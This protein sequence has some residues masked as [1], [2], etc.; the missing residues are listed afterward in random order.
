MNPFAPA[1][2]EP[3]IGYPRSLLA[4]F[5]PLPRE[6]AYWNIFGIKCGQL[7][8]KRSIG[9]PYIYPLPGKPIEPPPEVAR[10]FVRDM[11]TFFAVGGTGV[12]ADEIAIRQLVI[13][14][15]YLGRRERPLRV[16]DVKEM[17]LQMKNQHDCRFNRVTRRRRGN[18]N[19]CFRLSIKL[20]RLGCSALLSGCERSSQPG[21]APRTSSK[22]SAAHDPRGSSDS[23]QWETEESIP[24]RKTIAKAVTWRLIGTAEIFAISFWT[25]GHIVTAGH[26]AGIMA[27]SSVIMY[28]VHEL[29]W[30]YPRSLANNCTGD[31]VVD[32]P[33]TDTGTQCGR[34][35]GFGFAAILPRTEQQLTSR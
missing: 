17:F 24:M 2:D 33:P 26:T 32:L 13:L 14:N 31:D 19:N 3:R 23:G 21:V 9:Q 18:V 27:I 30:G 8:S 1:A 34:A 12:K 15:E 11:H 16:V 7:C 25:T 28:V 20:Y 35:D 6:R 10:A 4:Q 29:A 22:F 5:T